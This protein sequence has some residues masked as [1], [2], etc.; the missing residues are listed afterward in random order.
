MAEE[1]GS[2]NVAR[3]ERI[4]SGQESKFVVVG[5]FLVF[6]WNLWL[7]VF[8]NSKICGCWYFLLL[9]SFLMMSKTASTVVGGR[10]L[11]NFLRIKLFSSPFRFKLIKP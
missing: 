10:H 5:I 4:L 2:G 3:K 7:L 9:F 8:S 11:R 6:S 1:I